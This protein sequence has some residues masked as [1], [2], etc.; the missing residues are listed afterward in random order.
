MTTEIDAFLE[1]MR[2]DR[3][4]A[5]P[6]VEAYRRDL[7]EL[8]RWLPEGRKLETLQHEDLNRFLAHLHESRRKSSSIARKLSAIRQ[9]FRFCCLE[10]GLKHNP[11]ELLESPGRPERLPKFL[12]PESI[13]RLLRAANEGLPYTSG[14]GD[15]LRAR[16]RAILYL[17]YASGLRVSECAGLTPHQVDLQ[18]GY[19]RVRGKGS[20]ER[21]VPFADV[22]GSRL[23]EYLEKHRA[24]L[25]PRDDALFVNH[26]GTGLSRM[27]CWEIVGRLAEK[28][29]I[30]EPISPHVLRHSFATHLLNSGMN[31]R[32][33]Q[34][35]LGHSDL[36]TTQIYAH[37]SPAHLKS[38]HRK[39]HPRGGG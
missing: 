36:S 39:F 37:V 33:L 23:A 3:G 25:E 11:T 2:I 4:A 21:I 14:A 30:R 12:A 24:T 26:R 31:L 15:A 35:L 32:S 27:S 22:A 7:V 28:A 13:D 9:F 6:T 20:K 17:L 10:R 8:A 29:E 16:D 18:L 19:V 1:S 34:L 5:A 38:A